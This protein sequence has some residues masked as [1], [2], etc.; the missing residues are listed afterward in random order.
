MG[1]NTIR[2]RIEA[3]AKSKIGL[4]ELGDA[5]RVAHI[6]VTCANS[7]ALAHRP[8]YGGRVRGA[9]GQQLK[10]GASKSARN[11]QPCDWAT[12][13][14]LD[15]LFASQGKI[16][17]GLE[18][19]KPWALSLRQE[20]RDLVI[21]VAL[22]GMAASW[23]GEVADALVRG[24]RAGISDGK[25]RVPLEVSNRMITMQSGP[26][27]SLPEDQLLMM[28]FISPLS[29]RSGGRAHRNP[30]SLLSSLGN[31]ISGLA[32]WHGHALDISPAELK[33]AASRVGARAS[34]EDARETGPIQAHSSRHGHVKKL[35]GSYGRLLLP[36]PGSL[37]ARLLE[38]GLDA[39][40]GGRTTQGFGA[41]EIF[42]LPPF[43]A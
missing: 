13:C 38:L 18:V 26:P 37:L 15:I 12:P 8:E 33:G 1:E 17:G 29:L 31:R 20:G 36:A 4:G 34:W 41:C 39:Q 32:R 9:I 5:W 19:P 21:R 10:Q 40:V 6:A 24:L 7:A 27:V 23:A 2:K 30:A 11:G 35:Q 22:F 42:V 14:A 16:T 28:E 43:E 3:A 25:R